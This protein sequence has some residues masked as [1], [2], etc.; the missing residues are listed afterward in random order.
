MQ[1][2]ILSH[3]LAMS[4]WIP[5]PMFCLIFNSPVFRLEELVAQSFSMFIFLKQIC[6]HDTGMSL[7]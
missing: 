3:F 1:G 4:M 2:I 6:D 5:L 7:L